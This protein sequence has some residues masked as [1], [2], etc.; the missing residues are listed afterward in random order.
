LPGY[1]YR[2]V[3]RPLDESMLLRVVVMSGLVSGTDIARFYAT[4]DGLKDSMS[5]EEY[6]EQLGI[7]AE[8]L[9]AVKRAYVN[10]EQFGSLVIR[11]L[12]SRGAN[13]AALRAASR[14]MNACETAQLMAIKKGRVAKPL[15]EMLVELGHISNDD[16]PRIV[17]KQGMAR[18]IG[19]FDEQIRR[20]SSLAGRLGLHSARERLKIT[21]PRLLVLAGLVVTVA[22]LNVWYQGAFVS[23]PDRSSLVFGGAFQPGDSERHLKMIDQH[24]RNMITELKTGSLVNARHYRKLL[25]EYFAAL[26]KA[27]VTVDDDIV[28]HIHKTYPKLDFKRLVRIPKAKLAALSDSDLESRLMK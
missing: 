2:A 6:L 15:G 8:K 18:K 4:T 20:E 27:D 12:R 25:D 11:F 17:G 22:L 28:A 9:D 21:V 7:D 5:L 24:Y 14:A 3:R 23:A 19:E 10:T 1:T 16:L 26:E 13:D